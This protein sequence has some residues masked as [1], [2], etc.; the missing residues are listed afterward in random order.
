MVTGNPAAAR[1]PVA[2]RRGLAKYGD[3]ARSTMGP[4]AAY[5][6]KDG[7]TLVMQSPEA[8][9]IAW[10]IHFADPKGDDPAMPRGFVAVG[11]RPRHQGDCAMKR[12]VKRPHDT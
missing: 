3:D 1:L 5:R 10:L 7:W 11:H 4:V 8:P 2:M 6:R 9:Q 12:P